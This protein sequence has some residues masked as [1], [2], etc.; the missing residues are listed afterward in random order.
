MLCLKFVGALGKSRKAP[1]SFV[2]FV[3]PSVRMY[4]L[5]S[6]WTDLRQF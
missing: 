6:T 1:F 2:L 4:V 5:G 3:R